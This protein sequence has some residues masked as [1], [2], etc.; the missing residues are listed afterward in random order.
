MTSRATAP[1][2]REQLVYP[3]VLAD[4]NTLLDA[5]RQRLFLGAQGI[6][7]LTWSIILI[8][9]VVTIGFACVFPVRSRGAHLVMAGS[10]A[11]FFG[12]M[13]FLIVS[14]DHP[15]WGQL[16]VQPSAFAELQANLTRLA[17]EGL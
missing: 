5:R 8:G 6:G 7:G 15:L 17:H 2:R 14:M 1:R 9:A 12:L 3:Q 4:L 11:A 13:L 16:S 10:L